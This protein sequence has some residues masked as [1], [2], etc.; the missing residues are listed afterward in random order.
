MLR[1][2]VVVVLMVLSSMHRQSVPLHLESSGVLL[3]LVTWDHCRQQPLALLICSLHLCRSPT[4]PCSAAG[5]H[6]DGEAARAA[7]QGW[8]KMLL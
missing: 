1:I 4:C 3:C 8:D 5:A 7:W 6:H 2:P